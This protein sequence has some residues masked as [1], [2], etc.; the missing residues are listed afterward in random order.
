MKKLVAGLLFLLLASAL[1]HAQQ[2]VRIRGT[3]TAFDGSTL[4]LTTRGEG[5]V[6]QLQLAPDAGV[7]TAKAITLADLPPN[8][9]VGA[10]ALKQGEKLV[11]LEVHVLPPAVPPGHT[12]WDLEPG[13]T[14]TNGNLA[15]VA[16]VSGGSEI[17]L[18]YNDGAQKILV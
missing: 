12:P 18:Q 2:N 16:R 6:V 1:A 5:K 8:A 7:A 13:S 3:I 4:A 15:G 14:M 10:A 17:T 11:A 9:Y